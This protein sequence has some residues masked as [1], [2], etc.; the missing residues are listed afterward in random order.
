MAGGRR[1]ISSLFKE[2]QTYK[3]HAVLDNAIVPK[4]FNFNEHLSAIRKHQHRRR[5]M[6]TC[7]DRY[8]LFMLDTS[9]SVGKQAFE[10]MVKNL[11]SLVPLFCRNTKIAAITFGDEIYH[12]FCFNCKVNHGDVEIAQAVASIP[13]HGGWTHTG[14][15][16]K[17]ACDE[18][19]TIPC[20]LPARDEYQRCPAPIDVIIITDGKFNGPLDVCKEA[21]CLHEQ[22]FYDVNTF[23]IGVGNY[24]K[25]ELDCITDKDD[26]NVDHVFFMEDLDELN[27][28]ITNVTIFLSNPINPDAPN[29]Q[30]VFPTCFDVGS[31]WNLTDINMPHKKEN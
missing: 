16:V 23:T 3:D 8:L 2:F 28:F 6:T 17:C 5:R 18:I 25:G 21:K 9:G 22:S 31:A 29:D 7:N 19:L 30:Q 15:A 12:E 26:L 10:Y 4:P 27:M 13:Y 14:R 11:S 20:G 24:D 1:D